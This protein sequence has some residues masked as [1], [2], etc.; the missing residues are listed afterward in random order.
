MN[1]VITRL[2]LFEMVEKHLNTL[3]TKIEEEMASF[4]E[5]LK[6]KILSNQEGHK[7]S[8][9]TSIF[10]NVVSKRIEYKTSTNCFHYRRTT[11]ISSRG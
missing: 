5:D 9:L 2:K 1:L 10:C 7:R 11:K 8:I 6:Q 4:I 3:D